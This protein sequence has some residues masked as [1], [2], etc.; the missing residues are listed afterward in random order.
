MGESET[1]AGEVQTAHRSDVTEE[2]YFEL[3]VGSVIMSRSKTPRVVLQVKDYIN[4]HY[5]KTQLIMLR[6]VH[7]SW[8]SPCIFTTL[9]KQ[10]TLWR[11]YTTGHKVEVKKEDLFCPRHEWEHTN[12]DRSTPKARQ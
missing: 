10:D 7:Q 5:R 8:T 2:Q 4:A 3:E 9:T 12:E 6:K 11:F 1:K